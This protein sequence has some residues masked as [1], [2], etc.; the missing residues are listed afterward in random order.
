MKL[1][2]VKTHQYIH[3][4]LAPRRSSCIS[5]PFDVLN[6]RINVPYTCARNATLTWYFKHFI[7]IGKTLDT[8]MNP[9]WSAEKESKKVY[10]HSSRPSRRQLL[11]ECP[12]SSAQCS[13]VQSHEQQ[14]PPATCRCWR[15]RQSERDQAD[16]LG[17]L[18]GNYHCPDTA[19]T[20]LQHTTSTCLK[21]TSIC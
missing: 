21:Y 7:I 1:S 17:M 15:G 14:F 8:L 3:A 11:G 2:R 10:K 19:H 13:R 12:A 20:N 16:V 9:V 6:T 18:T 5:V 4:L